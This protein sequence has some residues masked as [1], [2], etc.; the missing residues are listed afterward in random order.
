M[1]GWMD[2]WVR[3]TEAD[4]SLSMAVCSARFS[5]KSLHS[6]MHRS[7]FSTSATLPGEEEVRGK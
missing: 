3:L 6:A 5:R 1:D 2:G 4:K 7:I